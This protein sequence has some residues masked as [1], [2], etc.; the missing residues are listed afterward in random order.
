MSWLTVDD[1]IERI[2]ND[3]GVKDKQAYYNSLHDIWDGTVEYI[4]E[5][6]SNGL[7]VGFRPLGYFVFEPINDPSSPKGGRRE[8]RFILDR[9]L[10]DKNNIRPSPEIDNI[11]TGSIFEKFPGLAPMNYA[12]I[13]QNIGSDRKTCDTTVKRI[14]KEFIDLITRDLD[15]KL[16]MGVATLIVKDK[17]AKI[18]MAPVQFKVDLTKTVTASSLRPAPKGK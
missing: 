11:F 12:T 6:V 8:L 13:G 7:G 15:F 4:K 1:L 10:I 3:P 9:N 16:D 17:R 14:L 18:Q 2:I 5:Q